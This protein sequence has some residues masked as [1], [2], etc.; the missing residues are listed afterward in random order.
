[1]DFLGEGTT[2]PTTVVKNSEGETSNWRATGATSGEK[3]YKA[4]IHIR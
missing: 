3:R 4:R 2:T 1:M